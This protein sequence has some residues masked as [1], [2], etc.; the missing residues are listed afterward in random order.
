MCKRKIPKSASIVIFIIFIGACSKLEMKENKQGIHDSDW[1]LS[2][3]YISGGLNP[4]FLYDDPDYISVN[5]ASHLD[6]NQ[7]VLVYKSQDDIYVYPYHSMQVEV[8]NDIID[9][10]HLAITFCPQT[11]SGIAWN[12]LI[13]DDTLLLTASGYLYKDN[14]MPYD[15]KSGSIWSQMLLLGA[16]GKYKRNRPHTYP[17]MET[18]WQNILNFFPEAKV[19]YMDHWNKSSSMNE[20]DPDSTTYFSGGFPEHERILGIVGQWGVELFQFNLFND[21]IKMYKETFD[22]KQI[23]VIGNTELNFM[24]AFIYQSEM[25]PVQNE[26][27]IIM[28]DYAGTK[29]NVFGEA[30]SGPGIGQQ[31]SS[32]D[33]YMALGWAWKDLF[34]QIEVFSS[35]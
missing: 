32:P 19:F 20:L 11:R 31:L 26:F 14:L 1:V 7:L 8:V 6:S 25:I 33:A 34:E 10:K 35:N 21:S 23:I 3:Q 27:P 16:K 9:N 28:M 24:V 18:Q 15:I 29:W 13:Q 17:L 30:V 22:K 12:R 2:D 4:F 5:E